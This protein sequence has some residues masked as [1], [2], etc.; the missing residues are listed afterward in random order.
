[1]EEQELPST[2]T[3]GLKYG[4]ISGLLGVVLFMIIDFAGYS[5]NRQAGWLSY[6]ITIVVLVLAQREY[7]QEGDG[8][9]DYREG[10]TIG[11]WVAFVGSLISGAFI[12][13]YA[14]IINPA[15]LE[16]I[17]QQSIM[18]MEERGMSD[19]EIEQAMEMSSMF[20]SPT[21]MFFFGFIGGFVV[22]FVIALLI[23][24]ITKKSRPEF[25]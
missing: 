22:T 1:M 19:R 13:I 14:A 20:M 7:K 5:G 2:R 15:Y 18:S 21:A 12:S 4:A 24:A 8:H 9:M 6:V 25:S 17:K 10:I 23:S 11:A 16:N 3:L